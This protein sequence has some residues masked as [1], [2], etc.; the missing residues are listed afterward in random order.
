M[1]DMRQFTATPTVEELEARIER[2]ESGKTMLALSM[3]LDR[4]DKKIEKLK[5]QIKKLEKTVKY[6]EDTYDN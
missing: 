1:T 4:R 5:R 3:R 2:F 6:W